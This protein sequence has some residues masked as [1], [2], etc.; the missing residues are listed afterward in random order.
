[1]LIQFTFKNYKSFRDEVTLDLS[2]TKITEFSNQ[3]ITKG[4]EKLLPVSAIYGANASGKSNVY[5]AFQYMTYY[6][7]ESFGFGGDGKQEASYKKTTP[8]A[9]D[10]VSENDESTFEVFF[11]EPNDNTF[12]VYNY[13]FCVNKERVTEEWLNCKAKTSKEYRSIFYRNEDELELDGIPSK[14]RKNIEVSLEKEALVVSLGAKLKIDKL[15]LVRDWFLNNEIVD[16]GD[17]IETY[18]RSKMLPKNFEKDK[19]IQQDVLDYIA[20]FDDSIKAFDVEKIKVELEEDDEKYLIKSYHNMI[21]SN[22]KT[23][24][25]LS[26]ESAGTLKMFSLYPVL[27]EVL[28][29]GSVLFVD[30]LNAKLH[31]LLVRNFILTFLNS[32][33]NPNHAQLVFTT[34]DTWQLSND[35]LRRDAVWFTDKDA[36]GISSLYSLADFKNE[37]GSKIRKDESFEKNYLLGKYGAIPILK[38][39]KILK[40]E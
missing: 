15:K 26:D 3:V 31:P 29:K 33:L 8:F 4:K 2:A 19:N 23:H 16:F 6:V 12:K 40:E 28:K 21:D 9:F 11:M 18:F 20:T 13:G 35:L 36:N 34:H 1:M 17:P 10:K 32:E 14:W 7:L 5:Q 22:E 37:D 24:I 39:M 38:N 25:S 27:Q 30:E